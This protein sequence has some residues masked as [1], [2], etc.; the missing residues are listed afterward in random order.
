M[1][2]LPNN[3]IVVPNSKLAQA[4]VTNFNLPEKRMS[5]LIP[6]SVSDDSDP[7]HVEHVLIDEAI[8]GSKH[9]KGLLAEPKP[10]VRFIPGFGDS[11][12]DFT[13][14]CQ[15]SE[16]VDQFQAHELRKRL[17]RRFREEGLEIPFPVR[18]LYVRSDSGQLL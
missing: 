15:V 13:L 9:I 4:I 3:L 8:R 14:I 1:R 6:V 2:A 16:F 12:L 10:I 17:F 18:T 7:E 5:L 11:S